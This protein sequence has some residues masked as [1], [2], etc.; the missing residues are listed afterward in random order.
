MERVVEL[1]ASLLVQRVRP[2]VLELVERELSLPARVRGSTRNGPTRS[3][4]EKGSGRTPRK[5]PGSIAT[6]AAERPRLRCIS[7]S[8]PPVEWPITTGFVCNACDDAGRVIGDLLQ[9]L[10]GERLGVRPGTSIGR[11]IVRPVGRQRD[12]AGFLESP[13]QRV[14]AGG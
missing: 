3:S 5:T 13:A 7:A 4:T 1:P 6:V 11:R 14:P 10:L 12:V 2:A 8:R 9:R